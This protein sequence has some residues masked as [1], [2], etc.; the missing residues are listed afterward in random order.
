MNQAFSLEK[1]IKLSDLVKSVEIV[2]F[3]P[4]AE[5]YFVNARSFAVGKQYTLI[6]DDRGGGTSNIIL[7]ERNGKFVRNIGRIGKGPG[8][9]LIAWLTM[10]DPSENYSF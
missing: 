2:Q 1:S 8:E 5:T 10:M 6:A 4:S 7:C 9:F 3:Y